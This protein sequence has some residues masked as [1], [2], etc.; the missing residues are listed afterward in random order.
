MSDKNLGA[1]AAEADS[2][3]SA[4][5]ADS[6][7]HADPH[8]NCRAGLDRMARQEQWVFD[9]ASGE[10]N[11]LG[12]QPATPPCAMCRAPYQ[13]D[14]TIPS[15]VW[16]RVVRSRGLPEYL[17]TTCIVK[18]F[19]EAGESFTATLWGG[20]FNGLAID[21]RVNWK[22]AQDAALVSEENTRLRVQIRALLDA[23]QDNQLISSQLQADNLASVIATANQTL[24]EASG[25]AQ[26]EAP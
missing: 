15:R 20:K 16:N 1:D 5:A 22:R 17:C 24:S 3:R 11:L 18:V 6:A 4:E 8:A 13:F 9:V 14:T 26:S 25:S 10:K 19:A 21:L 12:G 7:S 2:A 23:M